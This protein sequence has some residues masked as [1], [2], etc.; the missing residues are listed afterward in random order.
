MS[1]RPCFTSVESPNLARPQNHHARQLRRKKALWR[2]AGR[3]C[4]LCR[5]RFPAIVLRMILFPLMSSAGGRNAYSV[6]R[7]SDVEC[8]KPATSTP[9]HKQLDVPLS[10]LTVVCSTKFKYIKIPVGETLACCS[11][12][13]HL[14]CPMEAG[15]AATSVAIRRLDI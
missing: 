12:P 15:A 3:P 8:G 14:V 4:R 11:K 5:A 13:R 1:Y 6:L 2:P 10:V 7:R 9:L